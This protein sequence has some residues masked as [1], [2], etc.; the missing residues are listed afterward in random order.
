MEIM[1]IIFVQ[2][3][4]LYP[5]AVYFPIRT[6]YLTLKIEQRERHKSAENTTGHVPH[7]ATA[8]AVSVET[9]YPFILLMHGYIDGAFENSAYTEN[10]TP[11]TRT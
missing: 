11:R 8:A 4:R 6:L 2:V 5:Q 9:N 3:G 7:Q 10:S 1:W